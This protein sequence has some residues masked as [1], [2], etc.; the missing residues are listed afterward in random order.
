[1]NFDQN[2]INPTL[3]ST[4]TEVGL[5][6]S[7]DEIL[8][9][10][11]KR[12]H[13]VCDLSDMNS[14]KM[15]KILRNF[16]KNCPTFDQDIATMNDESRLRFCKSNSVNRTSNRMEKLN[17]KHLQV[18]IS[19]SKSGNSSEGEE[20]E[21]TELSDDFSIDVK[22]ASLHLRNIIFKSE[23]D[24]C[25]E[26]KSV[27][28]ISNYGNSRS[29]S[30]SNSSSSSSRSNKILD[31]RMDKNYLGLADLD[32]LRTKS[33]GCGIF[34]DYHSNLSITGGYSSGANTSMTKSLSS[35]SLKSSNTSALDP[36]EGQFRANIG[37][38]DET[39]IPKEVNQ[40]DY[41]MAGLVDEEESGA[42]NGSK[43]TSESSMCS[44]G[45]HKRK[46]I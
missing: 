38:S 18:G 35:V 13:E 10:Y 14:R 29:N 44:Q 3:E 12:G 23:Y 20:P 32:I 34:S 40:T 21:N 31:R 2:N 37:L 7:L 15:G 41:F 25:T 11:Q 5:L 8:Q 42:S 30:S 9:A 46:R 17:I 27:G 43:G 26:S 16:V 33:A 1:M 28:S 4:T 19:E 22:R 24:A 39:S 36:E 6:S 45:S